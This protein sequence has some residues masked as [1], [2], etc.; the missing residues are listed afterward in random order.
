MMCV[1]SCILKNTI[2]ICRRYLSIPCISFQRKDCAALR[3]SFCQNANLGYFRLT[4]IR[5]KV[6]FGTLS[7]FRPKD[8][9]SFRYIGI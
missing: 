7:L 4:Y 9:S 3:I 5:P 1:I 6:E 8:D 2:L